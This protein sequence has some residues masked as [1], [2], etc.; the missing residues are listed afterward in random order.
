MG[1]EIVRISYHGMIAD[2]TWPEIRDVVNMLEDMPD[3]ER[4]ARMASVVS[5][6]DRIRKKPVDSVTEQEK[7][8]TASDVAIWF[9]N[10]IVEGRMDEYKVKLQ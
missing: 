4:K 10:E 2:A 5:C 1:K 6:L 8:N 7:Q 3:A 9:A